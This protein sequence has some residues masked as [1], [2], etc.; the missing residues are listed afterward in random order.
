MSSA[1]VKHPYHLIQ[2]IY[3]SQ[4]QV[5][6]GNDFAKVWELLGAFGPLLGMGAFWREGSF[7]REKIIELG[8]LE[9]IEKLLKE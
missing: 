8:V 9:P 1:N 4:S 2:V 3:F 6:N 5:P 7:V